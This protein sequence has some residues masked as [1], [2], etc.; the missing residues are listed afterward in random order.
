MMLFCS[1]LLFECR[2]L[3]VGRYPIQGFESNVKAGIRHILPNLLNKALVWLPEIGGTL[4]C[5]TILWLQQS[6]EERRGEER[7]GEE[8]RGKRH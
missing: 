5:G 1:V 6:G 8:R 7:R 2:G 3:A 4:L